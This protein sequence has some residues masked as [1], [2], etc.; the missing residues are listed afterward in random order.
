MTRFASPILACA[1]PALALLPGAAAAAA[2]PPPSA[3]GSDNADLFSVARTP[4]GA[5]YAQAAALQAA[6]IVRTSVDQPVA[7]QSGVASFGF[8]CGL[9]PTYAPA[10]AADARGYDPEGKFVGA[11]LSFAF[12]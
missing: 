1:L 5:A 3:A 9:Q 11:K 4:K 6:G 10:G 12:R 2:V 7:G 8:L